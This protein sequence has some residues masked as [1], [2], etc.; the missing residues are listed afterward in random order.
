MQAIV[1]AH[2]E[3]TEIGNHQPLGGLILPFVVGTLSGGL[4]S[5]DIDARLRV[6]QEFIDRQG[7]GN[8]LIAFT[9]GQGQHAFPDLLT[10]TLGNGAEIVTVQ[11]IG[12]APVLDFP[13]QIAVV[14][15]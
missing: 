10:G 8:V 15:P 14:N 11:Q 5:D 12:N 13:Q 9:A 7:S 6:A 2:R 3:Q 4:G 1:A